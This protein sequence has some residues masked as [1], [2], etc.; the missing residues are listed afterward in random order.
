ME[1]L[2]FHYSLFYYMKEGNSIFSNI[3]VLSLE[4]DG[5]VRSEFYK[6]QMMEILLKY[7]KLSKIIEK[8]H[9]NLY[10]KKVNMDIN[11]HIKEIKRKK[12]TLKGK[13]SL[14]NKIINKPF[15][16]KIPKWKMYNIV[17]P[18][19][20]F[21]IIKMHHAYGD[22]EKCSEM[23]KS[24]FDIEEEKVINKKSKE[25][26][27]SKIWNSIYYFFISLYMTIYFLLFFKKEK[28]FEKPVKEEAVYSNIYN[29]NITE[30]K[31]KK[32]KLGIT[33]NDLLYSIILKSIKRY[34]NKEVH[35]S[36]SSMINL[37]KVGSDL[38]ETN[39]FGFITFS[40]YVNNS[41][42]FKKINT[43]MNYYKK[44][45]IIPCISNILKCIFHFSCPLVIKFLTYIFNKNH[46]GYSNYN[47]KFKS[48]K[49]DNKNVKHI[50][51][52]VIP[53]KQDVFFSLLTYNNELVLNM[54]FKKGILDEY[55]FK[56][57]V[58]EV[59][60]EL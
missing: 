36:S 50:G 37:R 5:K 25:G 42:L 24:L 21:L 3:I 47:T 34:S 28:I 26:Y 27:I 13:N 33:M 31:L 46:F 32:I 12:Y 10:W 60:N 23:M 41:N 15:N 16:N 6:I 55:K 22:G 4:I 8:S 48:I 1:F 17:Y 9:G 14:I 7:P 54:C 51:N 53:Y 18:E 2:D 44:S 19:R 20:S 52:I 40:T 35:L 45:P 29:F 49:I 58:K 39:N 30:L 56:K 43:Q 59:Y 57:C 38:K 11:N